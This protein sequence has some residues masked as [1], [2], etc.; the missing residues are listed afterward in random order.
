MTLLAA[1]ALLA[2]VA[3]GFMFGALHILP[4]GADPISDGVSVY[5]LGP[6]GVLYAGQAVLSGLGGLLLAAAVVQRDATA[7][8]PG[9]L[10]AYG[11]ARIAIVRFPTD[12]RGAAIT[13]TGRRHALL[14][15]IAFLAIAAAAPIASSTVVQSATQARDVLFWLAALV[16]GSCLASFGVALWPRSRA[17]YGL[18]QRAFYVSAFTWLVAASGLLA[19][20]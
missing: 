14:A 12:R 15:A 7:L 16:S 8:A 6:T 17:Y 4:S 19:F 13:P 5:A 9:L 2:V 10:V 3:A 11:L 18:V 1:A 20:A